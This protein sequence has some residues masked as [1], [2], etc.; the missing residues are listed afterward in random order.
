MSRTSDTATRWAATTAAAA[1]VC[2]GVAFA[3]PAF[4]GDGSAVVTSLDDTLDPGTLRSVLKDVENAGGVSTVRFAV[5]GTIQLLSPLPVVTTQGITIEGPGTDALTIQA[6][7]SDEAVPAFTYR[8]ESSGTARIS[9]LT[10]AGGASVIGDF[11]AADADGTNGFQLSDVVIDGTGDQRDQPGIV[12]FGNSAHPDVQ[13]AD[14]TIKNHATTEEGVLNSAA[15]LSQAGRVLITDSTFDNNRGGTFAGGIV[16]GYNGPT[17]ITGSTF[18]ANSAELIGGALFAFGAAPV[19]ITQSTFS[20]NSSG[21][22]GGAI[23]SF[24]AEATSVSHSTI[25]GNVSDGVEGSAVFAVASPLLVDSS[26]I[27]VNSGQSTSVPD[28]SVSLPNQPSLRSEASALESA[29]SEALAEPDV[30]GAPSNARIAPLAAADEAAAD[31]DAAADEADPSDILGNLGFSLIGQPKASLDAASWSIQDSTLFE[32][33]AELG[34]LADN[35]GRTLTHLPSATSPA[36]NAGNLA[37]LAGIERDQRNAPR[38]VGDLVDIGSVEVQAVAPAQPPVVPGTAAAATLPETGAGVEAP[39][40]AI[41]GLLLAGAALL[42][43]RRR[44]FGTEA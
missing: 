7:P 37:T 16:L 17:E 5:T 22:T 8:P 28:L 23:V 2:S 25:T 20:G 6:P 36:R 30:F 27:S 39:L 24:G 21:D 41:A 31:E 43:L 18:S 12:V 14:S 19:S 44:R 10:L 33:D 4:A 3:A 34:A 9:G 35:G 40:L 15:L 11:T 29:L 42:G 26:I 1:L 38:V 13:I 32:Q